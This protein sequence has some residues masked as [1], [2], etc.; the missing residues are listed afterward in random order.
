MAK[1]IK[2]TLLCV[3]NVGKSIWPVTEFPYNPLEHIRFFIVSM[4][5]Q[6]HFSINSLSIQVALSHAANRKHSHLRVVKAELDLSFQFNGDWNQK[7]VKSRDQTN[8]MLFTC[9]SRARAFL[10]SIYRSFDVLLSPSSRN[11]YRFHVIN[12]WFNFRRVSLKFTDI[13][14]CP[15]RT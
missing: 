7:A 1:S 9:P 2:K 14:L 8:A 3:G 5:F 15:Q 10:R 13:F 4:K 6:K 11:V 12:T